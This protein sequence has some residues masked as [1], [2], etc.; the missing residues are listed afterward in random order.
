[1][2][3][4][5]T[6]LKEEYPFA[7]HF[8]NMGHEQLHYVDEGSGEVVLMLHGNPTW[9]FFY[10]NVVKALSPKMRCLVPDHIGCGLSSKPQDYR[11]TLKQHIDNIVSLLEALKIKRFHL[12]VHDWG[13]AIGFGVARLLPERVGH[14]VIMNTAAYPSDFIPL[15]INVCRVP[16]FNTIALRGLNAFARAAT[17]MTTRK[18]LPK[19]IKEGFLAPYNSW[20]NRIATLRFVQDI[21]MSP[22][23]PSY[24]EIVDI[25]KH[26]SLFKNHEIL[27]CWGGLDWCFNDSFFARWT[28]YFPQAKTQYFAEAGHYLLE[29]AGE[30]II[31]LLADFFKDPCVVP[32]DAAREGV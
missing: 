17:V 30:R 15:R 32:V 20:N 5:P 7:S 28:H 21:P 3:T 23:H 14:I 9:S 10:R 26:L 4:L 11:Y 1:M 2:D 12:V 6:H 31:P 25:E 29:D 19:R 13:G 16:G 24:G 22:N 8:H 18:K 27:I